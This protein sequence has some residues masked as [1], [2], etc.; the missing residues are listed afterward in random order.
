MRA[1]CMTSCPDR[2]GRDRGGYVGHAARAAETS[3]VVSK[4]GSKRQRPVQR[5]EFS[6]HYIMDGVVLS[7]ESG[8]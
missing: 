2:A 3:G 7:E 1:L 4:T 6:A 5:V 8:A